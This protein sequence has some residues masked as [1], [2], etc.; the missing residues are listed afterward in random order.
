VHKGFLCPRRAPSNP[1]ELTAS[2]GVDVSAHTS[3]NAR[4]NAHA[5]SQMYGADVATLLLAV[6]MA[7]TIAVSWCYG[8]LNSAAAIGVTVQ[9]M[10]TIS[11]EEYEQAATLFTRLRGWLTAALGGLHCPT[12]AAAAEAADNGEPPLSKLKQKL[13]AQIEDMERTIQSLKDVAAQRAAACAAHTPQPAC[14]ACGTAP[15]NDLAVFGHFL[16]IGPEQ[17]STHST[18]QTHFEQMMMIPELSTA[19]HFD[20]TAGD[21]DEAEEEF[22]PNI[23]AATH[24]ELAGKSLQIE[25]MNGNGVFADS[26]AATS[27]T[28]VEAPAVSNDRNGCGSGGGRSNSS[29]GVDA[30]DRFNS[31]HG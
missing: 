26:K 2:G 16:P 20:M 28:N 21:A 18:K 8:T 13:S 9:V 14:N 27:T 11:A 10:L 4:T 19:L 29:G 25:A 15:E 5:A 30:V 17:N 7:G 1:T 6:A 12:A 23:A 22:Y 31:D 3:G 24:C